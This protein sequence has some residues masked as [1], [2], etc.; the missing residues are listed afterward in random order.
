M[1]VSLTSTSSNPIQSAEI[2]AKTCYCETPSHNE[3]NYIQFVVDR[4]NS[5]H[6]TILQHMHLQFR[7]EGVSRYALWS[8]FHNHRFYNT[9][10]VSQRYVQVSQKNIYIPK[11]TH[12]EFKSIFNEMYKLYEKISTKLTEEYVKNNADQKLAVKLAQE[13]ARYV[14]PI[15]TTATLEHSIDGATLLKYTI[16]AKTNECSEE[17]VKIVNEMNKCVTENCPGWSQIIQSITDIGE[18]NWDDTISVK[19]VF[20]GESESSASPC[21]NLKELSDIKQD[22]L[23]RIHKALSSIPSVFSIDP[24]FS[25][26]NTYNI[27][28]MKKISH[29]ADSQNQRH[30]TAIAIRKPIKQMLCNEAYLEYYIPSSIKGNLKK[31]FKKSIEKIYKRI[32][33][34]NDLTTMAYLLPNATL[35]E[36]SESMGFGDF[37]SKARNRL[38]LCAQTEIRNITEEEVAQIKK[39]M[40]KTA[41]SLLAKPCQSRKISTMFQEACPEKN[42]CSTIPKRP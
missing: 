24:S 40:P 1:K 4:I 35:M 12:K 22:E 21:G 31:E 27:T 10:Q 32:I 28:F 25:Y 26:L 41:L 3:S 13:D 15:C 20:E 29:C 14:L 8:F 30:R 38:C 37:M 5:G 33:A 7:I 34:T 36:I 18:Q 39:I 23:V 2:A 6:H 11:S 19:N 9:S 16:L 17:V 42:R